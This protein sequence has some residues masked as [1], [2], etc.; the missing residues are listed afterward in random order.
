MKDKGERQ[1]GRR[2]V[3]STDLLCELELRLSTP[4]QV[5]VNVRLVYHTYVK[6]N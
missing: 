1:E 5:T 4:D 3:P 2:I 6:L